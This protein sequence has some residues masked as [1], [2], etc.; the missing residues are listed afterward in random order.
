MAKSK[1]DDNST[2]KGQD[3]VLDNLR[4]AGLDQEEKASL[5]QEGPNP[6]GSKSKAGALPGRVPDEEST[7]PMA[8]Q[9][10]AEKLAQYKESEKENQ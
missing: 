1:K 3:E 6:A 10:E 2:T 8:D 9:I 7:S 5:A 4:G